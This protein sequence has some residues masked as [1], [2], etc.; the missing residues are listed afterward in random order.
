[1]INPKVMNIPNKKIIVAAIAT[2]LIICAVGT[3]IVLSSDN[4][5]KGL[6]Q[7][8]AKVSIVNMGQCSATPGVI[9]AIDQMYTDYY[10]EPVNDNLTIDDAKADS[11]FWN[12]YCVWSPMIT[13]KSDGTF[14]VTINTAVNG[15]EV[16]NIPV[17]DT[18]V[19]MGTMYSETL[20][21]L[22]CAANN[23]E[24]YSAESF[25]NE[26]VKNYLNSTITG[27]MQYSYYEQ[28]DVEY[29]LKCVNS[30]GYFDLGTNSTSTVDSEKLTQALQSA[31]SRGNDGTVYFGSG[32]VINTSDIYNSS[33]GPCIKT[34][35]YY[36]FFSPSTFSDIYS[37][38]ECMGLIMGFSHYVIN[39]VIENIQLNLYKVYCSVQELTAG[40]T[41]EKAYWETYA[42]KAVNT[43]MAKNI[44]DFLGFDSS[45]LDGAEHDTESLLKDNPSYLIF[46]TNDTRSM[47]EKMRTNT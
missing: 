33:T 11:A 7:L 41:P 29:M 25:A 8:D 40:K 30:S 13:E 10:G 15:N 47:D 16:V 2:V 34:G 3:A 14:N 27:G 42:G 45:L 18:A 23:V 38:I 12:E 20:Y 44:L 21:F 9:M 5:E 37:S 17:C 6:Y 4:S 19:I 32:R 26:N 28:Y 31:N 1:M 24:P 39:E 22:I 46:F 35:S 43:T 36:A